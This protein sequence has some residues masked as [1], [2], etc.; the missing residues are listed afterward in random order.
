[1]CVKIK[2]HRTACETAFKMSPIHSQADFKK[3][4]QETLYWPVKKKQV[5][6]NMNAHIMHLKPAFMLSHSSSCVCWAELGERLPGQFKRI[7]SIW[8][9]GAYVRVSLCPSA[10]CVSRVAVRLHCHTYDNQTLAGLP[11]IG[12]KES[13]GRF[14]ISLYMNHNCIIWWEHTLVLLYN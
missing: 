9:S 10:A 3:Y 2:R 6:E 8:I 14:C 11:N 1:M 5:R 4:L 7:F 12:L 13:V